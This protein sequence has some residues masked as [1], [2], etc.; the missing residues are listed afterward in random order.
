MPEFG[1]PEELFDGTAWF[2]AR[3]RPPYPEDAIDVLV[4][5]LRL[6]AGGSK[7]IDLGCGTG[8]VSIP[9]AKRGMRVWAI[10][11]SD[12]MLSEAAKSGV[13]GIEWLRGSDET[14]TS[15]IPPGEYDACVI[16]AAFHWMQRDHVLAKLDGV[17]TSAAVSPILANEVSASSAER[18]PGPPPAAM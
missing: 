5:R 14:F 18:Q 15:V 11:P 8:Q 9:L 1:A 16:G 12:E 10:D 7:V 13:E 6:D 3:Y 17:I 2:Y 4:Q